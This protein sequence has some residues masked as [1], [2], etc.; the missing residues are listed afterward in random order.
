MTFRGSSS[1][2]VNN[3]GWVLAVQGD[4]VDLI[5]RVQIGWKSIVCGL[6]VDGGLY[7]YE[8][9]LC[10]FVGAVKSSEKL[11]FLRG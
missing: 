2:C 7:E 5:L 10:R 11:A 1:D 9:Y 4:L 8:S 6:H 3:A